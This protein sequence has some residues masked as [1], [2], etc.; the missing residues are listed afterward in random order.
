MK[1]NS[2]PITLVLAILSQSIA[3][4]LA[5]G[6]AKVIQDYD[7]QI[8]S[9]QVTGPLNTDGSAQLHTFVPADCFLQAEHQP[10]QQ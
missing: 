4:A 1:F 6:N 10:V 8:E 7:K 9:I 5:D 3:S 2:H